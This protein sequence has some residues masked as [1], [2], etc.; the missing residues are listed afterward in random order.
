[1]ENEKMPK[2][3]LRQEPRKTLAPPARRRT[4]PIHL[5]LDLT[6]TECGTPKSPRTICF[7][8]TYTKAMGRKRFLWQKEF[9]DDEDSASGGEKNEEKRLGYDC[10]LSDEGKA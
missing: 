8:D 3:C 5:R 9:K 10:E 6:L 1:M 7:I 2:T 4:E